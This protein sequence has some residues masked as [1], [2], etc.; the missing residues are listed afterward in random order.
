MSTD[1]NTADAG[2]KVKP[3]TRP[4]VERLRWRDAQRD[5]PI[6]DSTVLVLLRN[7][8]P[9]GQRRWCAGYWDAR[10]GLWRGDDMQAFSINTVVLYWSE[11]DGPTGRY[12]K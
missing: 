10:A 2:A 7:A 8:R 6:D 12:A 3:Q 11:P 1:T 5:L 4:R 9:F